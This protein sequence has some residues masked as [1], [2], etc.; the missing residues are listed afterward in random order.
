MSRLKNITGQRFGMLTVLERAE[1][2]SSGVVMWRCR[3]DCGTEKV[4]RGKDIKSGSTSSCGC[5]RGKAISKAIHKHGRCGT[6]EYVIWVGIKRRCYGTYDKAYDRYGG[7]G[8]TVCDEWRASFEAF[9]R[10]MGP[11]PSLRHTIDR[12]DNDGN[13][14]PGNCRWATW[15]E[16]LA[17]R[18]TG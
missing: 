17:N 8:I 7:R 12:I 5:N 3:C 11:R 9:Y 16:Q 2:S 4:F 6:T 18:R 15:E 10:D 14:E 1:N 13:Y